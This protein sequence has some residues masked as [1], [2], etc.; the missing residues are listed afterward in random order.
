[1][2]ASGGDGMTP[3][4]PQTGPRG[5][6][7]RATRLA[8]FGLAAVLVG[9]A[10]FTIFAAYTTR[11]Q[12]DQAEQVEGLREAY[13]RATSAM[14]AAETAELEYHLE[15]TYQHLVRLDL[16]NQAII[17]AVN[18]AAAVGGEADARAAKDILALHDKHLEATVRFTAAIAAGDATAARRIDLEESDPL[19]EAIHARLTAAAHEA[20]AANGAAFASLRATARWALILAPVIFAMGFVLMLALWRVLEGF[21]RAQRKTYRE[22]EQ[23]SRLRSE[24]VSIVSHEFRT[25]LTGIQGFSEMMRDEELTMSR[26]REYAGDINKDARRLAR[27]IAD[28]LDLD[29]MESGRMT[30]SSEAVDLNRIVADS[31]AQFRLSAADHPIELDLDPGLREIVGDCDR[32]TQV[33]TNLLSNAI[34]YSPAGGPVELRTR[35]TDGMVTL[36]IRD[37]GLGIPAEYLEKIF[38]RYSRIETAETRTIKGT[39]LG[40]P[41]VRQI[42][43]LSDGK[44]WATSEPG[45]GSVF[46]VQLPLVEVAARDGAA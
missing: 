27:L 28:M 13:V 14:Q 10:A 45:Q 24:F 4:E 42:V 12:V 40:L 21:H 35:R 29:R 22:I 26:M 39:G 20:E 2:T 38:E 32:L 36:T 30:L 44:V 31:A 15:P 46:H 1:M 8:S 18:E 41:I 25:P 34:K 37:H 3:S 33:V 19:I 23:L 9:L 43:H 6:S 11:T 17:A 5:T 7:S 16:A